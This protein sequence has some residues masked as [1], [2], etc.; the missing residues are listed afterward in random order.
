MHGSKR[1]LVFQSVLD[2]AGQMLSKPVLDVFTSWHSYIVEKVNTLSS[3]VGD[4]L[5]VTAPEWESGKL[6]LFSNPCHFVQHSEMSP[7]FFCP[8]AVSYTNTIWKAVWDRRPFKQ[9]ETT[10]V[11]AVWKLRRWEASTS[12]DIPVKVSVLILEPLLTARDDLD[13][14]AWVSELSCVCMFGVVGRGVL[15]PPPSTAFSRHFS[16]FLGRDTSVKT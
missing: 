13:N 16:E 5:P 12:C 7:I 8:S 14:L 11:S 10:M 15:A 6:S 4:S 3:K 2:L 9:L 1:H